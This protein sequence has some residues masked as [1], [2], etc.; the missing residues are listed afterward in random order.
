V[1]LS[2]SIYSKFNL[3][4]LREIKYQPEYPLVYDEID[5]PYRMIT[6]LEMS[7]QKD[8]ENLLLTSEGEWPMNPEIGVGLRDLLFEN[9]S[10]D[11]VIGLESKIRNQV[12]ENL[13]SVEIIKVDLSTTP[14]DKDNNI[15]KIKLIYSILGG[16]ILSSTVNVGA[17]KSI[18]ITVNSTDKYSSSFRDRSTEL[19]SH[20]T[21]I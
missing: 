13:P 7:I 6:S 11:Q 20:I 15:L 19:Q 5:G 16:T 14:E 8:F 10:S 17:N 4:R 1:T 12:R 2:N 3:N 21:E 18:S 9:H